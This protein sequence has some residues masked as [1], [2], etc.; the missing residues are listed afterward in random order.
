MSTTPTAFPGHVASGE[1][2]ASTWG[3]LVSD[4]FAAIRVAGG[5]AM[6]PQAALVSGSTIMPTTVP[7]VPYA[8]T[9]IVIANGFAGSD[10]GNLDGPSVSIMTN[11][12]GTNYA[13]PSGVG[14]SPGRFAHACA[15]NAW[16]VPAGGNPS[17]W[18]TV[19]WVTTSGGTT[20]VMG[21][22]VWWMVRQ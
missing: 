22:L 9:M 19:G 20:Y 6:Q 2:I 18:I 1:L 15:T 5:R 16:N 13:T 21:D 10:T 17:F 8:S 12:A 7:T 4:A 3:N 14:A 11:I